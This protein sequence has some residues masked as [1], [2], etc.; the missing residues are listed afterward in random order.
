MTPID[1]EFI[2]SKVKVKMLVFQRSMSAQYLLTPLL[3]NRQLQYSG[4][5]LRVDV[6]YQCSCHMVKGQGQTVGLNCWSK[7]L[8]T[9]YHMSQVLKQGEKL[10]TANHRYAASQKIVAYFVIKSS[11]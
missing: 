6:P 10:S 9:Q 8:S 5:P 1:F 3:E 7:V 2:W 4:C 11:R